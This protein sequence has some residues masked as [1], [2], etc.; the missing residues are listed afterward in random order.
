[1]TESQRVEQVWETP[2]LDEIPKLSR[3]HVEVMEVSDDDAVWQQAGM[4]HVLLRTIGRT[5]GREHKVALPTWLDPDGRRIVVASFAG[6]VQHP[7][8]YRNLEDRVANPEV[9][10]RVQ[11]Q[12]YWSEPVILDGRR[13]RPP[14][15]SAHRRPGLVPHLSGQDR[16]A[17]PAGGAPGDPLGL[18]PARPDGQVNVARLRARP[19]GPL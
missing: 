15:G 2:P 16:P 12:Q 11:G 13:V 8:W 6:A 7:Q 5:T 14:L 9:L 17:D 18:R 1:M 4:H 19:P 10:C 3:A